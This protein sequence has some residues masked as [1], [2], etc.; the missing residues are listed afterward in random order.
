MIDYKLLEAFA[1]VV[2]EG[3][4]EKLAVNLVDVHPDNVHLVEGHHNGHLGGFGVVD[5]LNGLRHD[6][7]IS[8]DHQHHDIGHLCPAGAHGSEGFVTRR[9]QE[10]DGEPVAAQVVR[11]HVLGDAA[12]LAFGHAAVANGIQQAGLAVVYMSEE[13]DDGGAHGQRGALAILE[14]PADLIK[15]VLCGE[16]RQVDA[17]LAGQ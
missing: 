11:A 2:R 1:M 6:A 12:G 7:V 15:R 16:D 8:G 13:G 14:L 17:E 4:F 5:R 3:G 10:C 9:I